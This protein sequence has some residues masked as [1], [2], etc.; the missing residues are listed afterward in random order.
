[1]H[2]LAAQAFAF[3]AAGSYHIGIGGRAFFYFRHDEFIYAVRH[4]LVRLMHRTVFRPFFIY[5]FAQVLF[6][7]RQQGYSVDTLG[8]AFLRL[9]VNGMYRLRKLKHD[10]GNAPL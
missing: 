9:C 2:R 7:L 6:Y 8:S 10:S 3:A 5:R 1:M 4:Y